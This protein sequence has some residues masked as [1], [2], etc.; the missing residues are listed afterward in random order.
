M[1]AAEYSDLIS[2]FSGEIQD[3]FA[4]LTGEATNELRVTVEKSGFMR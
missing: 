1:S 3:S 2:I 4:P